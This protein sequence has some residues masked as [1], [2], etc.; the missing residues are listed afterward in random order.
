[1]QSL[2]SKA[3]FSSIRAEAPAL[4]DGS[5]ENFDYLI[6][7]ID[8][9]LP[10][11][12][13][14]T[15]LE[16]KV[17]RMPLG[18]EVAINACMRGER[19]TGDYTSQEDVPER[20]RPCV[21]I[22][23]ESKLS[24]SL[25]NLLAELEREQET[26]DVLPTLQNLQ[27]LEI[28]EFSE[29]GKEESSS[30]REGHS[31]C[32]EHN[33]PKS[34][35]VWHDNRF[36]IA[37]AA[38][39]SFMLGRTLPSIP[40]SANE[41][42]PSSEEIQSHQGSSAKR[43]PRVP[44]SILPSSFDT[45]AEANVH[46]AYRTKNTSDTSPLILYEGASEYLQT[47]SSRNPHQHTIAQSDFTRGV[48]ASSADIG[49]DSSHIPASSHSGQ[50][51]TD[52]PIFGGGAQASGYDKPPLKTRHR[53]SSST[54]DL[55]SGNAFRFPPRQT[56]LTQDITNP[57]KASCASNSLGIYLDSSTDPIDPKSSPRLTSKYSLHHGFPKREL[58]YSS[59][60][61]EPRKEQ[62]SYLDT[63][64]ETQTVEREEPLRR[65]R[66]VRDSRLD[67][68][69]GVQQF[70]KKH[71]RSVSSGYNVGTKS[72]LAKCSLY[73]K[74][75]RPFTP[76]PRPAPP[77]LLSSSYLS[78]SPTPLQSQSHS[79]HPY[80]QLPSHP[81]P[82]LSPPHPQPSNPPHLPLE[83]HPGSSSLVLIPRDNDADST[84]GE[85]GDSDFG[86]DDERKAAEERQLSAVRKIAQVLG[87]EAVDAHLAGIKMATLPKQHEN[88]FKGLV[89]EGKKMVRWMKGKNSSEKNH[90]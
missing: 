34:S 62:K 7:V 78:K 45:D 74:S 50:P 20:L 16:L 60:D 1:M 64:P 31:A 55:T 61:M 39:I 68:N 15:S 70:N 9:L 90:K 2:S 48:Q 24:R 72:S 71:L 89:G 35:F 33:I 44:Q 6:E 32:E 25:Q 37:K 76:P 46:P 41:N 53:Y 59:N 23:R 18:I 8:Q 77:V 30:T 82:R 75:S 73:R 54:P 17:G 66:S 4:E 67:H 29:A 81:Y 56:S 21:R 57:D 52:Q 13:T 87:Q 19:S 65:S 40:E 28:T 42:T 26:A 79:L 10:F 14:Q 86:S 47:L 22:E 80:P 69:E 38:D 11:P 27:D 49:L 5:T 85:A 83:R 51:N 88:P 43:S 58:T 12:I 84:T 63:I 3:S 36:P